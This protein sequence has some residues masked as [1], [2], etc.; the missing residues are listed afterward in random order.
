[1]ICFERQLLNK[2]LIPK[3]NMTE[4]Y[5]EEPDIEGFVK[6]LEESDFEIEFVNELMTHLSTFNLS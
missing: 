4:L 3:N 2:D 6:K 5:F 1:M